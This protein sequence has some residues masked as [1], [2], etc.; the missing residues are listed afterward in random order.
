MKI[1][2]LESAV[3][4]T[5]AIC[6][7]AGAFL[8][9]T[10]GLVIRD[11]GSQAKRTLKNADDSIASMATD[12]LDVTHNINNSWNDLYPDIKANVETSAVIGRQSSETLR[13]F[14]NALLEGWEVPGLPK[15]HGILLEA[16]QTVIE[17]RKLIQ[18]SR[19]KIDSLAA[20]GERTLDNVSKTLITVV[21]LLES[22]KPVTHQTIENVNQAIQDLDKLIVS[23]DSTVKGPI[24]Q[25]ADNVQESTKSLD[26]ALRPLR[27]KA[28]RIK[29]ILK[30]VLG[31]IKVTV[32]AIP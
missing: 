20:S 17:S 18:T 31:M 5:K 15:R 8:L 10:T 9:I 24:H 23:I 12:V 27:E 29:S 25:T 6:Y 14:R 3:L 28:G 13:E 2:I 22:N 11:V 30:M 7:G 1:K 21:E 19:V 26:E 4:T 16:N 32:P